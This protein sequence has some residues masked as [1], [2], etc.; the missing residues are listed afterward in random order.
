MD[1][2]Q[3]HCFHNILL[4]K[5]LCQLAKKNDNFFWWYNNVYESS[6]RRT[7]WGKIT[8]KILYFECLDEVIRP[9]LLMLPKISGYV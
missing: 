3:N 9:L 1:K 5:C 4:E 8:L 6:K 2:N 7:L